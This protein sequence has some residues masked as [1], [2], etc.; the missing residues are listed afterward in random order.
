MYNPEDLDPLLVTV[1]ALGECRNKVEQQIP[2]SDLYGLLAS[3]LPQN[4]RIR[5]TTFAKSV[6]P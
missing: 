5:G 1:A 2:Y 4:E 6:K 3:L